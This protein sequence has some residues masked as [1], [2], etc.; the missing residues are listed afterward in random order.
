MNRNGPAAL[1]AIAAIAAEMLTI[2]RQPDDCGGA[3]G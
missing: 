3:S 2:G 1:R